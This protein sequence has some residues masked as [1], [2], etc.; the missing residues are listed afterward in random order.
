MKKPLIL[1]LLMASLSVNAQ[2][3]FPPASPEAHFTQQ[4]GFARITVKYERP[5][6]R[7]RKI[8]GGLVPYNG[9][10]W[11]TGAGDCSTIKFSEDLTIGGQKVAA[12]NYSLFSI[13]TADEWTIVLNRDTTMHG[14]GG[15]D[16]AKD[17][18]RFKAKPETTNRFYEAFTIEVQDIVKNNANLYLTWENISVKIPIQTTADEKIMAD[19]KKKIVDEKGTRPML[20]FQAANYYYENDKDINQALAWI[21]QTTAQEAKANF[22]MTQARIQMKAGKHSEAIESAKKSAEVARADK[23]ETAAKIAE[24]FIADMN[25]M[26]GGAMEHKH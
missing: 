12:G 2:L 24:A 5:L 9:E 14:T 13:P 7:G 4:V 22:L 1:A 16:Q 10:L 20:L 17:L 18:V 26:H 15:Y 19:I 6:A 25:K 23:N 3:N 21:Q 8:M 11:R